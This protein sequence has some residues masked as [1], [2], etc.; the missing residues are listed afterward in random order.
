MLPLNAEREKNDLVAETQNIVE[1]IG[2]YEP[3][4][5]DICDISIAGTESRRKDKCVGD[6]IKKVTFRRS[7]SS[8]DMVLQLVGFSLSTE[9][10][11]VGMS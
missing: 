1:N 8:R 4:G 10:A 5:S 3:Q 11:Y 2:I 6:R 7:G 9:L